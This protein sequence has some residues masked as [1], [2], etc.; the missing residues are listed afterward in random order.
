MTDV[1]RRTAPLWGTQQQRAARQIRLTLWVGH[2]SFPERLRHRGM[3]RPSGRAF[4][5]NAFLH[6]DDRV[7]CDLDVFRTDFGAAFGDVAQ[8]EAV[9]LAQ[10]LAPVEGVQWMHVQFGVA[11]EEPRTGEDGLVVLVV[12][13]DVADVLA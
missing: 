10:L 13:D 4:V 12:A 1:S 2:W 11:D 3:S 5:G 7:V 9:L 6:R 8:A